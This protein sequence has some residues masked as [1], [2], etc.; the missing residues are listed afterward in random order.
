MNHAATLP[1]RDAKRTRASDRFVAWL[2]ELKECHE[3]GLVSD[4]DFDLQRNE[5]L[6]ELFDPPRFVRFAT[7]LGGAIV[8]CVGGAVAWGSHF[9]LGSPRSPSFCRASGV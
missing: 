1:A 8:G 3:G 5:K 6:D 7:A 4:E 9:T 2:R